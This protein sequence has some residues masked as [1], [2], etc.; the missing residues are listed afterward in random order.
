MARW[1]YKV[2]ENNMRYEY[3]LSEHDLNQEGIDGW[4]LVTA[5]PIVEVDDIDIYEGT[6]RG[7][8]F[9]G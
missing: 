4:E 8:G 2:F 9:H 3:K 5:I 1:E 7:G 6:G